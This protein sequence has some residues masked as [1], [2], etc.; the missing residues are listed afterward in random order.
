MSTESRERLLE[1]IAGFK[2]EI[3]DSN[4]LISAASFAV[5]DGCQCAEVLDLAS[6]PRSDVRRDE[7]NEVASHILSALKVDDDTLTLGITATKFV[8]RQL[9]QQTLSPHEAC[10]KLVFLANNIPGMFSTLSP[11][12]SLIDDWN[13]PSERASVEQEIVE[14]ASRLLEI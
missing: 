11:F 8:A 9:L 5:A 6:A 14:R 13:N 4:E 10:N 3:A 7:L 2:L 12:V 1:A